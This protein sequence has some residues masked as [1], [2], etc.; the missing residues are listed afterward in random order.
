MV[1]ECALESGQWE[2]SPLVRILWKHVEKQVFPIVRTIT[3]VLESAA[4]ENYFLL[5]LQGTLLPL[6]TIYNLIA[7]WPLSFAFITFLVIVWQINKYNTIQNVISVFKDEFIFLYKTLKKVRFQFLREAL[8]KQA[9][10]TGLFIFQCHGEALINRAPL[11]SLWSFFQLL[12][13]NGLLNELL[14]LQP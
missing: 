12:A 13:A 3:D 10:L 5:Q 14:Q 4:F 11:I 8:I 1:N 2:N 7:V 6:F 9:P